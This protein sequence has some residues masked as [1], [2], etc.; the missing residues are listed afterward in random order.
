MRSIYRLPPTDMISGPQ[1]YHQMK[2]HCSTEGRRHGSE[3]EEA[4]EG[5]EA[6][7]LSAVSRIEGAKRVG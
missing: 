6:L 1:T 2:W 7:R 5:R 4:R 3:T